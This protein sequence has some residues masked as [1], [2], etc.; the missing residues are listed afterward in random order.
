[1][2]RDR[3]RVDSAPVAGVDQVRNGKTPGPRIE[4]II[5]VHTATRPI[6]RA[7]ASV[8]RNKVDLGVTV[9]AHNIAASVIRANLGGLDDDPRVRVLELRDGIPSPA[10]PMNHGFAQATGEYLSLLGS[11][12]ELEPGAL[13]AWS[14]LAERDRA[15]I[16]L[17]PMRHMGRLPDPYPP[18][19]IG[20]THDLDADRDRLAYRSAPLGLVSRARFGALRFA[21]GLHSGEDLPFVARLWFTDAR[22]SFDPSTPAYIVHLD[23]PDRVTSAPR[24]LADDFR[25]L[26]LIEDDAALASMTAGQRRA[27][28]VKVLRIHVFDAIAARLSDTGLEDSER[29]ALDQVLDRLERFGPG[30]MSLLSYADR[31]ALAAARQAGATRGEIQTRLTARWAYGRPRTII[32]ANPLLSLHRQG[33]FR[34]LLAGAIVQRTI[35]RAIAHRDGASPD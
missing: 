1:M 17:A 7:V 5:A 21:E 15:D 9:V 31:L 12:D 20:R 24:P 11:D 19:R 26:S 23:E 4:V 16:V 34:T 6:K 29:A 2:L 18:V 13:D 8:L 32:A 25:F 33:P 3:S 27:L 22:R 28:A 30:A 10:G 35:T 14:A